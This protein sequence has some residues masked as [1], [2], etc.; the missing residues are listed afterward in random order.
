V[1]G[2]PRNHDVRVLVGDLLAAGLF[3]IPAVSASGW[4]WLL[5]A[6]WGGLSAA[7]GRLVARS[8]AQVGAAGPPAG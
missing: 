7:Q 2:E 8:R 5:V 4:W 6:G 3:L 1:D